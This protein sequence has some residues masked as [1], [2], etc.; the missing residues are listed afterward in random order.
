MGIDLAQLKSYFYFVSAFL[1]TPGVDSQLISK[2]WIANHYRWIVWKLAA[3]EVAFPHHFAGRQAFVSLINY[4]FDS[5]VY[6][7]LLKVK[8]VHSNY[9]N[10]KRHTSCHQ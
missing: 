7:S 10:V 3:M 9:N 4:S 2:E 8:R 1:T 5:N 6:T